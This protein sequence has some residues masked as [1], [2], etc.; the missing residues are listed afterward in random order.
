M[1]SFLVELEQMGRITITGQDGNPVSS[2]PCPVCGDGFRTLKSG[3]Y[4]EF[5]GC[6]NYPKNAGG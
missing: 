4:G 2:T 6:T 1:L 5:F 3:Q